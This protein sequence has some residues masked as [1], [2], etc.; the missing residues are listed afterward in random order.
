MKNDDEMYQSL[1]SRYNDYQEKREK[2]IRTI[3]RT[4]PVLA[5]FCFVVVLGFG[6]WDNLAKLPNIPE[7]SEIVNHTTVENTESTTVADTTESSSTAQSVIV[8][9][10]S[11]TTVSVPESETDMFDSTRTVQTQTVT[12]AASVEASGEETKQK[13]TLPITT[14]PIIQTQPVTNIQTTLPVQTTVE[15]PTTTINFNINEVRVGYYDKNYSKPLPSAR[16]AMKCNSFCE[17]GKT[18]LID[19]AMGDVAF[20]PQDYDSNRVYEYSIFPTEGYKQ[21]TDENLIANGENGGYKKEYAGGEMQVFDIDGK[22]DDYDAY[23]HETAKIDFKNYMADSSGSITF[24][25]IAI[26]T[27]N[28]QNP[29]TEGMQQSLYFYVG[30]KGTAISNLSVENAIENYQIACGSVQD[31]SQICMRQG[32]Q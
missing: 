19:V 27:D 32:K 9:A 8:T 3:R 7:Q 12:T 15:T 16:I 28:P 18:L 26:F 30:E 29:S 6:L 10:P 21:I 23:H 4:V 20:Y 5:S 31:S 11:S 24:S 13:Q 2:R 22:Y 17:S 25:F 14:A 1:L